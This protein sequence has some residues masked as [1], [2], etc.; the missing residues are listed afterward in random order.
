[1][2]SSRLPVARCRP[3]SLAAA[4]AVRQSVAC[5]VSGQSYPL[6][7]AFYLLT[8]PSALRRPPP[9]PADPCS[10]RV[11]SVTDSPTVSA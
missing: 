3:L 2:R 4:R 10:P 8:P 11:E 9:R 1:M 5:R 6:T 7:G